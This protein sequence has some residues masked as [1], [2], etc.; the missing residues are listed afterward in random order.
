M[1]I[2]TERDSQTKRFYVV[3]IVL[4]G[5]IDVNM[6]KVQCYGIIV[7]V[8]YDTVVW[9]SPYNGSV[10]TLFSIDILN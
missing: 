5:L 2:P 8:K 9:R 3:I 1:R 10:E 4:D 7:M 6:A